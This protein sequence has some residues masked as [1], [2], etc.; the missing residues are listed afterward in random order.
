MDT[1]LHELYLFTSEK[2]APLPGWQELVRQA[3]LQERA[4]ESR[5]DPAGQALFRAFQD[6]AGDLNQLEEEALFRQGLALGLELGRLIPNEAACRR[7]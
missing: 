6:S 3:A 7:R 1:I 4:L 5:L 2:T